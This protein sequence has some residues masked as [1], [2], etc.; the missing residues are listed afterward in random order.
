MVTRSNT[1]AI[2]YNQNTI[3]LQNEAANIHHSIWLSASAGSGKTKVLIDRIVNLLYAGVSL[4][5]ILCVTFTKSA[6]LEMKER[7]T[8]KI[9]E[10]LLNSP[11]SHPQRPVIFKIYQHILENPEEIKILTLHSFCQIILK[12]FPIDAGINPFFKVLEEEE[13]QKIIKSGISIVLQQHDTD[14]V[15]ALTHLSTE[16][17]ESFLEKLISDSLSKWHILERIQRHIQINPNHT[18]ETLI[19]NLT[20]FDSYNSH[21]EIEDLHE[22][23]E[24]LDSLR[25]TTKKIDS[26][27]AEAIASKDDP[28]SIFLIQSGNMRAKLF[29]NEFENNFP[30]FAQKIKDIQN[31]IWQQN[32]SQF[33]HKWIL[34]NKHFWVV[35]SKILEHY[36]HTKNISGYVDFNDLILL[37]ISLFSNTELKLHILQK[38]DYSID[39]ILIDEAQ[40]NSPEQW[41]LI[42]QL[43]DILL[44]KEKKHRSFFVVGDPKQSI[45]GFQGAVPHLF[46]SL[47]NTFHELLSTRGFHFKSLKLT[48]SFRTSPDILKLVNHIFDPST[49]QNKLFHFE[50]H[51]AFRQTPG[52]IEICEV[53]KKN[54]KSKNNEEQEQKR[55][56]T[57]FQIL[58]F[59]EYK[60]E[61][62]YHQRLAHE[63][64]SKIK[65]LLKDKIILPS[66]SKVI[67]PSDI[68]ILLRKRGT[69]ANTLIQTLKRNHIATAGIDRISIKDRLAFQDL[70]A[71][72]RFLNLPQDDYSLAHILKSP[73]CNNGKGYDDVFLI[74]I[75]P[76]RKGCLWDE[77][78][79]YNA[80][81][82]IQKD[83]NKLNQYLGY[84]DY[85]SF[86]FIIN[87]LIQD[88][89]DVFKSRLGDEVQDIFSSLLDLILSTNYESLTFAANLFELENTQFVFKRDLSQ[90]DGVK[91]MTIHNSKGLQAP[92]IFL[93]DLNEKVSLQKEDLFWP[94]I[95]L[96][97]DFKSNPDS[98]LELTFFC[99]RP[100][101]VLEHEAIENIKSYEL[102]KLDEEL[103][104]L[105]YVGLTR[106]QDGLCIIGEG[107]WV[108]ASRKAFSQINH[109]NSLFY[110]QQADLTSQISEDKPAVFKF[111]IET[112]I[113]LNLKEL[114]KTQYVLK[115]SSL[116][117][118]RSSKEDEILIEI[119]NSTRGEIIH[120]AFEIATTQIANGFKNIN[121]SYLNHNLSEHDLHILNLW[122]KHPLTQIFF[123]TKHSQH[124]F[125]EKE[126]TDGVQTIR[127]D[128]FIL[129]TDNIA[130]IDYKTGK[131]DPFKS[132]YNQYIQQL[133]Y[134]HN[135]L[136]HIYQKTIKVYLLW[137]DEL[138]FE[139][140]IFE[141]V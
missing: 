101:A 30:N 33:L 44:T 35:I 138:M 113:S 88:H 95:H 48:Q 40:D 75:C 137:F 26:K 29:S 106:A 39:H 63:I 107:Q 114:S 54:P 108:E 69:F 10:D 64:T 59:N 123:N 12:K 119:S 76:H 102:N 129:C 87:K 31:Q 109:Q 82:S 28:Y 84:V 103:N 115:H 3:F 8:H 132:E 2:N 126:F 122:L 139:E 93:I 140:L 67:Q 127:I 46:L 20:L 21:P 52:W 16:V 36:Q 141:E 128:R 72:L 99:L 14:I 4:K 60:I 22:S 70:L 120:K 51:V 96:S 124:A 133:E 55:T 112:R 117:S 25:S 43:V 5:N 118:I 17:S 13:S 90:V 58:P 85:Q 62:H 97:E 81:P 9:R 18:Y 135:T 121:L 73:F 23:I 71:M 111:N 80:S 105:F 7:L 6:A 37:T 68:I 27:L 83:I 94:Q 130:I 32:Q 77:L 19:R 56:K 38:L 34:K 131:R 92:F 1:T 65:K 41:L 79:Q 91:I 24:L 61:D 134:Y 86:L 98:S 53:E 104:R 45:Y 100:P 74:D 78:K 125:N 57:N 116:T 50:N 11:K 136:H 110:K 49:S 47:Q 42:Y 89:L 15:Q 66:T